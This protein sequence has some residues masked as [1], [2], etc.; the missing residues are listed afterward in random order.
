MQNM[1]ERDAINELVYVVR[2]FRVSENFQNRKR[3]PQPYTKYSYTT[4]H[5]I[6]LLYCDT[7]EAQTVYCKTRQLR[8]CCLTSFLKAENGEGERP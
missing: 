4:T 1:S 2:I 5:I 6:K 3:D 7:Q 8:E